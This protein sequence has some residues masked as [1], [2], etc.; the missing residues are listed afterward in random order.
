MDE[1][2]KQL[3][4]LTN[5]LHEWLETSRPYTT[6]SR[7][8]IK[9]KMYRKT[10]LV[11]GKRFGNFFLSSALLVKFL[12]VVIAILQFISL[13]M[14]L[15]I[16]PGLFWF[17]IFSGLASGNADNI[18][19]S[20]R[21]PRVTLCD[22]QLRLLQNVQ[23]WTVQCVLPINL[24]NEKIFLFL[25]F[26]LLI[27]CILSFL[28]LSTSSYAMLLTTKRVAYIKKYLKL[29]HLYSGR[30][31]EK[32]LLTKFVT[33]YLKCDGFYVIRMAG[34]NGTDI[35]ISKIIEKL[36]KTYQSTYGITKHQNGELN[37]MDYT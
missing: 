14:F 23:S 17:D 37:T 21:F 30:K 20:S 8:N 7:T 9:S 28:S 11:C 15:D 32:R 12:Y 35:L 34:R 33:S 24:F 31:E 5:Y 22:F 29:R 26:W 19:E 25:W 1:K 27:L 36:Y 10:G 4:S 16:E 13:H 18:K 3:N 6:K 2:D